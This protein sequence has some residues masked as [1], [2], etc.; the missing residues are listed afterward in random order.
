[1][2]RPIS[3]RAGWWFR[4]R[5]PA[6][7]RRLL[8]GLARGQSRFAQAVGVPAMAAASMR[9]L[10]KR[11]ALKFHTAARLFRH[12][13]PSAPTRRLPGASL[14]FPVGHAAPTWQIAARRQSNCLGRCAGVRAGCGTTGRNVSVSQ[15]A[16]SQPP[17]IKSRIGAI[18][19]AT[20]GNFLEQFDFFLFGFYASRISR[21]R[22]FPPR[23]RPPPCSTLRRV[24]ARCP[25]APGRRDRARR[26]YRPDRPPQGPDRHAGDHGA[27]HRGD[28][29]LPAYARS[30]LP[31]R[32]SC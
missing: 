9:E 11:G 23:T 14:R 31:R 2:S 17:Q 13:T 4:S 27:G 5:Y 24:L 12:A 28:R 7:R 25:D 32:S 16:S 8:S 18:L 30:A 1:M 21:R 22:S 15:S 10:I 6:G 3:P 19:R 20:S 29:L 26:L